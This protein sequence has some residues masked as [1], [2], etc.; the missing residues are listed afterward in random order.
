MIARR[1]CGDDGMGLRRQIMQFYGYAATGEEVK[2]QKP[3]PIEQFPVRLL[4]LT[5]GNHKFVC[6]RVMSNLCLTIEGTPI[7]HW[8]PRN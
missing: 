6:R 3:M 2:S 4:W 7:Y 1:R 5:V 8:Y